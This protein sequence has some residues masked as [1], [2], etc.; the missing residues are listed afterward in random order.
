M[1][2]HVKIIFIFIFL[3]YSNLS[4]A[5]EPVKLINLEDINIIFQ[6][7]LKSWNQHLIFLNKKKSMEKIEDATKP[8]YLL[9]TYFNDEYV[10]I[11]P[12][13]KEYNVESLEINY[14]FLNSD[15]DLKIITSHFNN[16]KSIYCNSIKVKKNDIIINLK[17]C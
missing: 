9:K 16:F 2:K 17:K 5:I 3:T 8:A 12:L 1:T 11:S 6:T 10:I 14:N 13:F 7:D 4:Q 15:K